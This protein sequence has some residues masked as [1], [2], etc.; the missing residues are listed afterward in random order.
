MLRSLLQTKYVSWHR[1]IWKVK[2]GVKS[3]SEAKVPKGPRERDGEPQTLLAK[4]MPELAG[5][6]ELF[7]R[8]GVTCR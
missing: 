5:I 3:V 1:Q 4:Q 7:P 2:F 6:K 8:S